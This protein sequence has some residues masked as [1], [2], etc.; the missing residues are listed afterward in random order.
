VKGKT[1]GEA[2]NNRD[3]EKCQRVQTS[4]RGKRKL[5]K[6]E[7]RFLGGVGERFETVM[8]KGEH[9]YRTRLIK[10]NSQPDEATKGENILKETCKRSSRYGFVQAALIELQGEVSLYNWTKGPTES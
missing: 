1:G 2:R 10:R 3:G 5:L 4:P 9:N 6:G 8:S 7:R